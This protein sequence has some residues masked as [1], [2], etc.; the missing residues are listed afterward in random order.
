MSA[1]WRSEP[2]LLPRAM[3]GVLALLALAA[4]PM[5]RGAGAATV[6]VVDSGSRVTS[7]RV[8]DRGIVIDGATVPDSSREDSADRSTRRGRDHRDRV[9]GRLHGRVTTDGG[10]IVI[11]DGGTGIVRIWSDARVPVGESVEGEVVAVFGSVTVD[12]AVSRDVVAVFGSVH[13]GPT[14]RVDGDVVSIGGHIEQ[15][16]GAMIKGE[17]VQMGFSPITMG[18][19]ARSVI[20]F[21]VAA[22]WLVSLFTGWIL[23]LLFPAGMLRVA[24]VVERRPAGSFFLGLLSVPMFFI[25]LVLLCITVIGIPLAVLL[26]MIYMLMGYAGQ[27]AATA[28][29][30]ARLIRR[31]LAEGL[32]APLIVGTL[33]VAA[34]L[35]AGAMVLAGGGPGQPF[36]IFLLVSGGLLLLG[37]GA[38]GTGA[39]VLSRFGTRP[40]DVVWSG[41]APRPA[42]AGPVP[43]HA[44]PPVPG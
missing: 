30:G 9:R 29:L 4:G 38:L 11:D 12:G 23:A 31:P 13:L 40:R 28:V 41:H 16:P 24:T 18:L 44:P 35:G 7:I 37:L 3:A 19:P 36:A 10:A 25:A 39:F 27:L 17:S 6:S 43:G 22:G 14:A 33:F 34:L 15:S 5:A 2:V 42:D 32:M 1:S 26:P 8:S 20:L 21:A